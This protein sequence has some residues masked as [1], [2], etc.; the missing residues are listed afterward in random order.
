MK[1][2]RQALAP[3]A[4]LFSIMTAHTILETARDA[5]LLAKLGPG[6]LAWAY[7]AIAG[8]AFIAVVS[9][10]RWG[11]LRDPRRLLV[12]FL[13]VATLGTSVLAATITLAPSISFVLYVWTGLVAT[14]VVPAFWTMMDRNLQIADA[15]R[16]FAGIGAGGALGAMTG[17][18]IAGS[19]GR[20][21]PAHQLI[22]V[23]AAAFAAAA[24]AGITLSP[25]TEPV[26]PR[27][28]R[29]DLRKHT[30]VRWLFGIVL[31]STIA[32]T[33]GDLTFK[34]V[35]AERLP[36]E[37]LATAFGAIYT[38]LNVL[39]LVLQVALTP[40]L[41]S[42]FGV[43]GAL[44]ILPVIL[45]SSSL[46]FVATGALLAVVVMKLGDGALRHSL[47]RVAT[48]ILY[49]PMPVA[50]RDASKP[51]ADAFGQ[52]GGQA[53]AAVAMLALAAVGAEATSFALIT[54]VV[55]V[56]WLL[57]IVL[58]RNRYIQQFR[59]TLRAGELHRTGGIPSLDGT[60]RE[61]LIS[62]LSS[63]DELEALAALE[64][65]SLDGGRIPALMLY[66]PRPAVARR[67]LQ[68]LGPTP[69]PEIERVLAHL[70][71]HSDS[72]VRAAALAAAIR[73]GCHLDRVLA[74]LDDRDPEV[75]AVALLS[76]AIEPADRLH[77]LLVGS[78]SDRLALARALTLVP[79]AS[80]HALIPELL[81]RREPA[82]MREVLRTL[83]RSP[84]LISLGRLR[85]MLGDPHVRAEVRK[86]YLAAGERGLQDAI[87]A[88]DDP[89][90]PVVVRR[91]LPRTI[92][93]FGS[94]AGAAALVARLRREPDGSTEFKILRALGRMR[95]VDPKLPIDASI[96]RAYALAAVTDAARYATLA[97]R[98]ASE[99]ERTP[100]LELLA[101]LLAEKT[102]FAIE[103]V[104]RA[105][106]ILQ[107]DA[108]LHSV[109]DAITS[110]DPDRRGPAREI[111]EHLV[112]SEIRVPLLAVLD[113]IPAETRRHR[114]GALAA[115]PF[116]TYE[117]VLLT[118][119]ADRSE[120]L[121]C[122]VA[123][124]VAERRLRALRPDLA[125]LNTLDSPPLVA[126]AYEQAI[127]R[128]DA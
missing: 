25:R 18:A 122:V 72:Q 23:G 37:D 66:H 35:I 106:H 80:G 77:E 63:P 29:R 62:A 20:I 109:H 74:A 125:R 127:A 78:P 108:G 89:R 24:I 4:L 50:V 120:S 55:A 67:A 79:A 117:S 15:K 68:L 8:V 88:L 95:E 6:H 38:G 114:L 30:Y 115:G 81:A 13:V 26:A 52:R 53:V 16:L 19:L 40:L 17:S 87:E 90:T 2:H 54:A 49:V 85:G 27:T 116:P 61:L 124:H 100:G 12:A 99:T 42:R 94:R 112:R 70:L 21:I 43:G 96:I 33:I 14:L 126:H 45:V 57:M 64:L 76:G 84:E 58:V 60:S 3:A 22:A 83:A 59:D 111:I 48:E 51:I 97:D 5:L 105:L 34:R 93:L 75:R 128:L 65:L 41:L 71:D 103:H 82:V 101:E 32:L 11:R 113:P 7:L 110:N 102:R 10:R 92:S 28:L 36:P 31:V 86:V 98:L 118:L 47:H 9:F 44:L 46:G 104:F 69:G 39:S 121:R 107:P 119:L 73:S 1:W 56:G 91:H 123:H